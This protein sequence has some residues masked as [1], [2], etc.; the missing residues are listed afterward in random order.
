[1]KKDYKIDLKETL[2]YN[3]FWIVMEV[4]IFFVIFIAISKAGY[5]TEQGFQLMYLI[6]CMFFTFKILS[7]NGHP[8]IYLK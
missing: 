4:L 7:W 8:R 2:R 3:S 1:M 5:F 6:F